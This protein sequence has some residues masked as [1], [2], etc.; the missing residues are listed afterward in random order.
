MFAALHHILHILLLVFIKRANARIEQQFAEANNGIERW[1]LRNSSCVA[2]PFLDITLT[3]SRT[4]L[5]C[6]VRQL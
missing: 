6:S 2:E 3:L 4:S 1:H 5:V